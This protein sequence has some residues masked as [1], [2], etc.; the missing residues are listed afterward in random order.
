MQTLNSPFS[1]D[2]LFCRAGPIISLMLS[3]LYMIFLHVAVPSAVE[4]LT[5]NVTEHE[6]MI[7]WDSL[8]GVVS[9]YVVIVRVNGKE[10]Q[11]NVTGHNFSLQAENLSEDGTI[12]V[13]LRAVNDAGIGPSAT[14]M[15]ASTPMIVSKPSATAIIVSTPV[16]VSKHMGQYSVLKYQRVGRLSM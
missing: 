13:N 4:G 15:I 16:I 10:L 12:E 9:Y 1:C 14:A 5:L 3:H 7:R 11:F 2:S 6:F 8:V